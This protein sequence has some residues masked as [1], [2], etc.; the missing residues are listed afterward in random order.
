[1]MDEPPLR[2][3]G[4]RA[5][6]RGLRVL[7]ALEGVGGHTLAEVGRATDLSRATVRRSLLT[8][9]DLGYVRQVDGRFLLTPR[10]LELGSSYL[11]SSGRNEHVTHVLEGLSEE[12]D[13]ASSLA[14]LDGTEVL[15]VA[16][17][18]A[19][20]VMAVTIG[21]GRRFPAYRTALGRA[22]LCETDDGL[23]RDIWDRSDRS[24]PTPRTIQSLDEFR[25]ALAAARSLGY[26]IVEEELDVGLRSL[27]VP[28][29]DRS[30]DIVAAVNVS[31]HVSRTSVEV[32]RRR[33][34]PV[35]QRAADDLERVMRSIPGTTTDV[36]D[37]GVNVMNVR[38]RGPGGASAPAPEGRSLETGT[39]GGDGSARSA[40][41][42]RPQ[43][44]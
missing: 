41:G 35:L 29:R 20:H 13:E 28:V 24:D 23:I 12:L 1:M 15:Y 34:L 38:R 25:S 3:G 2:D 16:R 19:R 11:T 27:A 21:L 44:A 10:L 32:L 7:R 14:V 17:V 18:P 39:D 6:E 31:T 36:A 42:E 9:E 22:L 5:L 4:V 33:F 37:L 8:L 30:G 43:D 40:D 26:A